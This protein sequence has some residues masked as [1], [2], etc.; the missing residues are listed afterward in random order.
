MRT[1]VI[2][3]D[4]AIKCDGASLSRRHGIQDGTDL[5]PIFDT[6]REEPSLCGP[7]RESTQRGF[8]GAAAFS[9][10]PEDLAVLQDYEGRLWLVAV[11]AP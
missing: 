11:R 3:Y 7:T 6:P 4:I 2:K 8:N 5:E 1:P 9:K 10:N